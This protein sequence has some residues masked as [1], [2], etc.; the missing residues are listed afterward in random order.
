MSD[1]KEL[2]EKLKK[3]IEAITQKAGK[4]AQQINALFQESIRLRGEAD[5]LNK[6]LADLEKPTDGKD[7]V[8]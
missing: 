6:V 5:A 8:N 4:V 3:D 7:A 2:V 1:S